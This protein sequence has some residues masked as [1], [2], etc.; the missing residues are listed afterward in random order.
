MTL[1][2][3]SGLVAAIGLS[4]LLMPALA[5]QQPRESSRARRT[6]DE[7]KTP[8]PAVIHR[9]PFTLYSQPAPAGAGAVVEWTP[10]PGQPGHRA[11]YYVTSIGT[12]S[13]EAN[14]AHQTEELVRKL[15]EAT[16]ETDKSKIK[17]QL[18][19]I[20]DKQFDLRQK[21]HLDEIRELEGKIKRLK[22]LVEKRQENRREIV[23]KRIDQIMSDAEGLG[24]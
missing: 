19:E 22:E 24:W 2:R 1:K 11:G 21:R 7:P 20:L 15:A 23:A 9:E 16:P 10:K 13:E 14:L 5:Q 3:T 8:E 17:S 12:T 6:S 4:V 18:T